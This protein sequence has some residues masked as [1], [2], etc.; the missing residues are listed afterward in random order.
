MI[1]QKFS[2]GTAEI[3]IESAVSLEDAKENGFPEGLYSRFFID[4]KPATNHM[5]M[6]D[7]IV[8]QA[9]KTGKGFY[10]NNDTDLKTMQRKI[11]QDQADMLKA[12]YLKLKAQYAAMDAPESVLK[13]LDAMIEKIDLAGVRTVE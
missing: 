1:T 13:N 10:P 9:Q 8:R 5:A 6:V 12:G 3:R 4:G 7:H 2:N 11:M